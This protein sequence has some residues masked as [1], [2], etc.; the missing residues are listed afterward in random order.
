MSPRLAYMSLHA[1]LISSFRACKTPQP[2]LSLLSHPLSTHK[3]ALAHAE[4]ATRR[5]VIIVAG[6][7][8]GSTAQTLNSAASAIWMGRQA[9][10]SP[11]YSH[12]ALNISWWVGQPASIFI[13]HTLRNVG[14]KPAMPRARGTSPTW[15]FFGEKYVFIRIA[16]DYLEKYWEILYV[17]KIN[18]KINEIM[19][20]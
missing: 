5:E 6:V 7:C 2:P 17:R 13:S 11:A 4:Q 15:C 1:I 14:W 8:V 18:T 9:I 12:V 10:L 3:P 20:K 19:N 16:A